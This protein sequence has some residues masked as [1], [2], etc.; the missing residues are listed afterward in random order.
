M[1]SASEAVFQSALSL[2]PLERLALVE[3]LNASLTPLDA[4]L[5]QAQVREV[6]DRV[7]AYDAGE[8]SAI[9]ADQVFRELRGK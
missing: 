5:D 2:P 1:S 8:M 3:A 6:L 4:T 7:R 9:P